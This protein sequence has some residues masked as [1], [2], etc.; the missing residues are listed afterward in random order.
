MLKLVNN[1]LL[2]RSG[3][4]SLR[5][6]VSLFVN[7]FYIVY[8]PLSLTLLCNSCLSCLLKPQI[9]QDNRSSFLAKGLSF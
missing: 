2:S 4:N 7:Y 9:K 8:P 6:Q 3:S 5:V 1:L